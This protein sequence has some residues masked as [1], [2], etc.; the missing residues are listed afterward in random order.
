[1]KKSKKGLKFFIFFSM[2]FLLIY[3]GI[4]WYAG[5]TDKLS[6][7]G[8]NGYFLY[9]INDEIY[10]TGSSEWTKLSD[11]SSNLKNATISIEDKNFYNHQ[12]F[13]FFRIC[14]ALMINV[15]NKSNSQGASTI[16]QQLSKNL[17]LNFD[18]TWSR[19]MREAWIT[20]RLETHYSKYP[21][22]I[23]SLL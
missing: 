3:F 17:F 22:K 9:D 2:I 7:K 21:S 5:K 13:D 14:K 10:T 6:I 8:A 12:G 11:I 23:L 15:K 1:M 19:K 16:T 20:L 4:Y 18:K